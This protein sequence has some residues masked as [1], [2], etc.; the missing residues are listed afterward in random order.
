LSQSPTID[1]QAQCVAARVDAEAVGFDPITILTILVQVLPMLIGCFTRKDSPDPQETTTILRKYHERNPDALLRRTAA[2]IRAQA[3]EP[4]TKSQAVQ[5]A[6]AVID[7]ALSV[8]PVT[9]MKCCA[10]G[11]E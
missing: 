10:E 11:H 6:Q 7:Q 5:L 9:A 3:D 8:D 2:R 4:M 1:E